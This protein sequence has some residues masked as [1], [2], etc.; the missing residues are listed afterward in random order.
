M[1]E[2]QPSYVQC[3]LLVLRVNL[4]QVMSD[5]IA[6]TL[7]DE[8]LALY[9]QSGAVHVIID[10]DKVTYLSSAGIRPLLSLNKKVREREGRLILT[11]MT[12]DVKGVFIATR[13]IDVGGSVSAM[14]ENQ[15]DVP[16]AVALLYHAAREAKAP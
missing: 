13:L 5:P 4:A 11:G 7:R 9:E 1:S 2:Q 6:D 8:F 14:F 15:P 12:S 16:T 3:P 10:M